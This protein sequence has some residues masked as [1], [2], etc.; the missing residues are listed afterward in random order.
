MPDHDLLD[1]IDD[2]EDLVSPLD[3]VLR[4]PGVL[5][6]GPDGGLLPQGVGMPEP[7]PE[8]TV[9]NMICL[10]GPCRYYHEMVSVFQAGNPK[11]TLEQPMLQTNRSC[12]YVPG[13]CTDLVDECVTDCNNWDPIDL[14]YTEKR[15]ERRVDWNLLNKGSK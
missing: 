8:A 6:A 15:N 1:D 7:I 10:R 2:P 14:A 4:A 13:S 12:T 9:E 3:A 5:G 11:G